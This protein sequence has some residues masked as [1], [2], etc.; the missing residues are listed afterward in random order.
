VNARHGRGL[1]TFPLRFP[2][3]E[4]RWIEDLAEMDRWFEALESVLFGVELATGP[5][6]PWLAW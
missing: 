6:A 3:G 4:R 2:P 1:S 5:E